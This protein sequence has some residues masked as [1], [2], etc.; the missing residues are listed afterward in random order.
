MSDIKGT[1]VPDYT[2]G[3]TDPNQLVTVWE[4]GPGWQSGHDFTWFRSQDAA[5]DEIQDD[6]ADKAGERLYDQ[7]EDGSGE[8]TFSVLIRRVETTAREADRVFAGGKFEQD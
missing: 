3:E 1:I 5:L 7:L 2:G 6:I 4:V 8:A